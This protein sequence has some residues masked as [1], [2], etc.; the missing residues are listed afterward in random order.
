MCVC[1]CVC[2]CVCLSLSLSLCVCVCVRRAYVHDQP[3]S[4]LVI[5][6]TVCNGR[7]DTHKHPRAADC[8]APRGYAQL[9]HD[10]SFLPLILF[11]IRVVLMTGGHRCNVKLTKTLTRLP[12]LFQ[13]KDQNTPNPF[14]TRMHALNTS[15]PKKTSML[16]NSARNCG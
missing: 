13:C 1:V 9:V 12:C 7:A 15:F 14:L 11:T 5:T 6:V 4:S 2:V 8:N 16:F 10:G 3:Q